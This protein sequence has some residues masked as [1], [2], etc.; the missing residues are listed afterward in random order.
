MTIINEVYVFKIQ[1][2]ARK[3]TEK[4]Q[5]LLEIIKVEFT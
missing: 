2:D 3:N 1:K 5:I 4:Y